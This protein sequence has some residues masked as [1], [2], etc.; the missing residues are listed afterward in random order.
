[1]RWRNAAVQ[2]CCCCSIVGVLGTGLAVAAL[3]R[4]HDYLAAQA[5]TQ[6]TRTVEQ[7]VAAEI[8]RY[9]NLL[10]D[11]AAAVGAQ[12]QLNAA[13]FTA[14]T[15]PISRSRLPGATGISMVVAAD[16]DQIT[17]VQARWR[18]LG[19]T[20]LMLRGDERFSSH[21]FV[22]LSQP[23]DSAP[24][25]LGRD[26]S[27]ADAAVD[28][29]R[30][31]QATRTVAASRPYRLLRDAGLPAAEQQLSTLL[32]APVFA[33][34]PQATDKGRFRGWVVIGLRGGDF[35]QQSIG[36][37]ARDTVAVTLR[38]IT[39]DGQLAV[40]AGWQPPGAR[41]D[42]SQS[43]V[44]V[45]DVLQRIWQLKVTATTRLLPD[46]A[47]HLQS[48]IW[49]TGALITVLLAALTAS[50]SS[51]RDHAVRRVEQ[52]TAALRDDITRREQIEE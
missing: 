36:V 51:S 40:L 47:L 30:L 14:I 25:S 18:S 23:L 16:R 9:S 26:L 33:T 10:S 15:A 48:A 29:L 19:A 3:R 39:T 43:K 31:S 45:I 52:A 12:T 44:V 27:T 7:T 24:A 34:S 20:A 17:Q 28:A 49:L 6:Q 11:M 1:M 2:R 41:T 46:S 4:G 42:Q 50:V 32:V 5:L 13:E 35:L 8:L 38:D 21:L 22:V 37:V